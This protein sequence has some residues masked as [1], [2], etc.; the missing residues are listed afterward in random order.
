LLLFQCVLFT[1][2]LAFLF[3]FDCQFVQFS[4]E[5]RRS[6]TLAIFEDYWGVDLNCREGKVLFIENFFHSTQTQMFYCEILFLTNRC[7]S[8]SNRAFTWAGAFSMTVSRMSI[9]CATFSWYSNSACFNSSV[10]SMIS[11]PEIFLLCETFHLIISKL[12]LL[13]PI[14]ELTSSLPCHIIFFSAG[15]VLHTALVFLVDIWWTWF[16]FEIWIMNV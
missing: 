14:N 1:R 5:F 8:A 7:R 2:F 4:F 13:Y 12:V 11:F 16:H 9:S 3:D 6:S 15:C 10:F